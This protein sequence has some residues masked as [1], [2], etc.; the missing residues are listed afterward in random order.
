MCRALLDE[1]GYEVGIDAVTLL[2][3]AAQFYGSESLEKL[4]DAA[5]QQ[6]FPAVAVSLD[7]RL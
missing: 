1:T 4:L 2:L 5:V 7:A 6:G 3:D